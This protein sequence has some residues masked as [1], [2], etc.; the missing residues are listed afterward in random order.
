MPIDID[1]LTEQELRELNHR[2]VDRLRFLRDIKAQHSMMRFNKGS[3][4]SFEHNGELLF[5]RLIKFNKKTVSLI[6]EDNVQWNVAPQLLSLVKE[7]RG[8]DEELFLIPSSND[9][10]E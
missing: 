4:V 1:Q 6:T 2:I 10:G 9:R 8:V 3:L 5:G 7:T